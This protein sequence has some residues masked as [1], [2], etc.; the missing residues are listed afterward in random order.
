MRLTTK[1][2]PKDGTLG[3]LPNAPK[4]AHN[5]PIAQKETAVPYIEQPP[6]DGYQLA[7]ERGGKRPTYTSDDP[8]DGYAQAIAKRQKENR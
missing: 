2:V 7:I 4:L 8:L 3:T 6:P 5:A 1:W